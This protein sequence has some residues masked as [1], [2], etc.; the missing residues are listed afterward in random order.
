MQDHIGVDRSAAVRR[1]DC[2]DG[3]VPLIPFPLRECLAVDLLNLS[4]GQGVAM[5]NDVFHP[6]QFMP[7]RGPQQPCGRLIT[8]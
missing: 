5:A 4:I 8:C 7:L 2:L 3:G 6:S 1:P